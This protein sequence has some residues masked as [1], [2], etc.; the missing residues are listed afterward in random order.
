MIK[1]V[2]ITGANGGLGK[3]TARQLAAIETTEKV[4]LACRNRRKAEDAARSLETQTGRAIFEVVELDTSDLASARTAVAS[5]DRPLDG[6]VMN[7]GGIIGTDFAARTADG[8]TRMLAVN[9]LGHV[10]L[11]EELLAADKLTNVAIF[12][13]SETAR[14][15]R[16]LGLK[17][18]RLDSG[19]VDELASVCD[20]SCPRGNPNFMLCYQ[21]VKFMGALYM[22]AMSRRHPGLRLLTVSPGST[23]G[24]DIYDNA[25]PMTRLMLKVV[26]ALP[27]KSLRERNFHGVEAGAKRYVDA[28][29]DD[30]Y[31]SGHFYASK[32]QGVTGPLVDQ[33]EFFAEVDNAQFQDNAW[34]ALHRFIG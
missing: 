32:R 16:N 24:T 26:T 21:Y 14:G 23:M 18:P 34:E 5:L 30:A 25:P 4:Y 27:I 9:L 15:V 17:P 7:A 20:G 28:L 10:V 22:G 29:N 1:S 3:E 12:S 2:M 13:G 8:V 31:L 33:G 11:L 6:L 19:S